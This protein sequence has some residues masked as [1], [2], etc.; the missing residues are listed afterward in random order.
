MFEVLSFFKTVSS[1]APQ[2]LTVSEDAGIEPKTV[3]LWHWHIAL[4]EIIVEGVNAEAH[5]FTAVVLFGAKVPPPPH[6]GT[7]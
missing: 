5:R 6:S 3:R 4:T 7:G 1:A 2:I